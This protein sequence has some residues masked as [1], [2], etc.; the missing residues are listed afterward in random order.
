M[1]S[2]SSRQRKEEDRKMI[3]TLVQGAFKDMHFFFYSAKN[4]THS[5]STEWTVYIGLKFK[6]FLVNKH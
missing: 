6:L 3:Y 1:S 5:K 4:L 2:V